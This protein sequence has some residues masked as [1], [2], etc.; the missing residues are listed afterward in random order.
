MASGQKVNES[1]DPKARRLALAFE[2]RGKND[3]EATKALKSRGIGAAEIQAI[4]AMKRQ[5]ET[6]VASSNRMSSQVIERQPLVDV[7]TTL[8]SQLSALHMGG[9]S[10]LPAWLQQPVSVLTTP[11]AQAKQMIQTANR[12]LEEA[13]KLD[14]SNSRAREHLEQTKAIWGQLKNLS[15]W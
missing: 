8:G 15:D 12:M 3:A 4:L 11:K 1:P 2:L 10:A 6:T 5:L 14:P 7:Q 13:V 9:Q